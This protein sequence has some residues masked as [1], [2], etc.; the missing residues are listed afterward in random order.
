MCNMCP[1]VFAWEHGNLVLSRCSPTNNWL[2]GKPVL[3]RRVENR[4]QC[5]WSPFFFLAPNDPNER[6]RGAW[7]GWGGASV[8]EGRE[9]WEGEGP[10]DAH[11]LAGSRGEG[12]VDPNGL[13][14]QRR[15]G[16]G[17]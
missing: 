10:R 15:G 13:L 6:G 3:H 17:I 8:L 16:D 14:G 9:G 7:A 11:R 4:D 2:V 1:C 12:G 5:L